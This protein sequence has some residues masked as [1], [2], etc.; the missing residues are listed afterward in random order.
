MGCTPNNP[1]RAADLIHEIRAP[2]EIVA[3]LL[4][5]ARSPTTAPEDREKM[6]E[7][8]E[9]K[10]AEICATLRRYSTEIGNQSESDAA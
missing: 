4:Y 9:R 6:L 3:N 1:P 8:A 10:A 2:L 7:M 5:L